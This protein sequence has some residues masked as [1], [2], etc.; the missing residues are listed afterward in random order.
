MDNLKNDTILANTLLRFALSLYPKF[1]FNNLSAF[2]NWKK[3]PKYLLTSPKQIDVSY[4]KK[5]WQH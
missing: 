3:L 2:G 4:L 5:E 1:L